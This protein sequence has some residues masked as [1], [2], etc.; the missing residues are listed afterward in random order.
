MRNQEA[1]EFFSKEAKTYYEKH[2]GNPSNPNEYPNLYLRHR[3][4]LD[5]L[6]NEAKKGAKVLDI[7]SGSGIMAKDLLDKDCEVCCRY[8]K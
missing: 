8:L 3:Y 5:L 6:K 4:I 2:Y 1:K 7:G